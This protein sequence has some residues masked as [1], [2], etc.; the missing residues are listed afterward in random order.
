M[1][2]NPIE[3]SNFIIDEFS[4]YIKST[5]TLDDETYQKN[6]EEQLNGAEL[7]NGPFLHTQLPFISGSTIADL[8]DK[9]MISR[10][11]LKLGNVDT[12]RKLYDHQIRS[13]EK[14]SQGRNV[15][16]TTG[17]GSG[18]TESFLYPIINSIMEDIDQGCKKPGIKAIFLY[19]MNAL[20]NDQKD[21]IRK[22]LADYPQIT[23]GSF[24]GETPED[25]AALKNN[26]LFAGKIFYENEILTRDDIRKNPPDLL[27]TNYSMLE[28]LL[29]RPQ[30]YSIIDA[31]NMANWRFMVLDEAH[32]YKG[33]LAIEISL[34]LRRLSGTAN[35]QPQYI[36]TSA[37]LGDKKNVGDIVNFAKSL[38]SSWYND[39]DIIFAARQNLDSNF[40]KHQ[41]ANADYIELIRNRDNSDSFYKILSKYQKIDTNQSLGEALYDVLI[42]DKNIYRL[43]D[44][45]GNT[46]QYEEVY[47]IMNSAIGMEHQALLSLIRLLAMAH[48]NNRFI[49]DAKFH[50]FLKTP[51]QAYIT[52]SKEKHIRIHNCSTIEG[53]KAFEMGICKNCNHIYIIGKISGNILEQNT[54]VDIYENYDEQLNKHLDYFILKEDDEYD[55]LERY[56]ICSK[57]GNIYSLDNVNYVSCSCGDKHRVE[58][59]KIDNGES[60]VKNN[61]TKCICCGGENNSG[62]IR[63]FN[64]NKDTATAIISQLF[65]QGMENENNESTAEVEIDFDIFTL[66]PEKQAKD[67]II[68]TKQLLAFSDSRQQASFFSVFF[69]YNH[70]R[71]LRRRLIFERVKNIESIRVSKLASQLT[72]QIRREKLFISGDQKAQSEAWISI[73]NDILFVDGRYG[74]EGLGLYSYHFDFEDY[75]Q[76]INENEKAIESIFN[77][78]LGDFYTLLDIVI[79]R[80]RRNSIIDYS[81]SELTD[82][83]R[84]DAFKYVDQSK[85]VVLKKDYLTKKENASYEDRFIE[86]FLPVKK[87]A[88]NQT[89]EYLVKLYGC[90]FNFACELATKLFALLVKTKILKEFSIKNRQSYQINVSD[91]KC[92]PYTKSKWYICEKCKRITLHNISDLCPSGKCDGNLVECNPDDIFINNYYRRHYMDK[93]IEPIVTKEHTAQLDKIKAREYQEDFKN[94]KINILSCSTTFE[95]GVD[96]G[97]LENVFLRNVPPSPANYVQRAGRAG[98]SR[99]ASALVVTYCGATPHDFAYFKSPEKLI[100][101]VVNPPKFKITNKKIVVRHILAATLGG[102]FRAYPEYYKNIKN[103]VS[104]SGIDSFMKFLNEYPDYLN[105]LVN[106]TLLME[107]TLSHLRNLAWIEDAVGANSNFEI[108]INDI[109]S[110]FDTFKEAQKKASDDEQYELAG[111]FRKQLS[112]L[113]SKSVIELLSQYAVIPKYGFPIDVVDLKVVN[114]KTN[115]NEYN[116]SRDLSIAISEYAPDSEVIVDGNKYLSRYINIPRKGSLE[117]YFYYECPKCKQTEISVTPFE[118]NICSNCHENLFVGN[119]YFLIPSLGFSTDKNAIRSRTLRPRKTYSGEIKYL[120]GGNNEDLTFD[121]Q[122]KITV[123]SFTDDNLLILNR[124]DFYYCPSCGYTKI[125]K[126]NLKSKIL[127]KKAHNNAYG[128]K[129]DNLSLEKVALGH[130]FKTDVIKLKLINSI[131]YDQALTLTYAILEGLSNSF[132]IERT[133]INGIVEHDGDNG[134]DIILFDNVPGGAGHVKRLTNQM[135]LSQVFKSAYNIVSKDCCDEDSSCYNCLRNYNN[136][137][138]HDKIKRKYAKEILDSLI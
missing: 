116:L 67:K 105:I 107:E 43:F 83:D 4:T 115:V 14:I 47:Q 94:G 110:K 27:F 98:R 42:G 81:I 135:E 99:D 38:T 28:Y 15:V 90:D 20:V 26:E 137:K 97:S 8:V 68:D 85:S 32:I 89:I 73:L 2:K 121:Y 41:I 86:S 17:T 74:S 87:S 66:A 118:H 127:E 9:N 58:L 88:K 75:N 124:S 53:Y 108:F 104:P 64:L 113:E 22:L 80:F 61:L 5:Y 76:L 91:F 120:G 59:Y 84:K 57:C 100:N 79:E 72:N 30:D 19:P 54:D 130:V 62:I 7:A 123:E 78:K 25:M 102:F 114:M 49:F 21:R 122:E 109:Q 18:K 55:E 45:I 106:K 82:Q 33:A 136:Q 129:C 128:F 40:I 23:Y 111:Y 112:N 36:L 44:A 77:L 126:N 131:G 24:I 16:I 56:S 138:F 133:D 132:Q 119:K 134:Y 13:L 65:Y 95:M 48:K 3:I 93:K 69:N 35:K 29:I 125:V 103:F 12:D 60:K 101:G 96:L 1:K 52:L 6:L 39:D 31:N 37:T 70:E 11:F 51:S 63:S 117:R 92:V 46:K 50:V 10:Q 34:L 71:F